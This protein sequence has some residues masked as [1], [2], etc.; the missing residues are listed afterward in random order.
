MNCGSERQIFSSDF[1]WDMGC[2][3]SDGKLYRNPCLT[4]RKNHERPCRTLALRNFLNVDDRNPGHPRD[5]D[6]DSEVTTS[7]SYQYIVS[8][9][10]ISKTREIRES[11]ERGREIE[12]GTEDLNYFTLFKG[13][14]DLLDWK[15]QKD[16]LLFGVNTKS[17]SLDSG[18]RV[19]RSVESP[20]PSADTAQNS[21]MGQ[22]AFSLRDIPVPGRSEWGFAVIYITEF[23]FSLYSARIWKSLHRGA[24]CEWR[25]VNPGRNKI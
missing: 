3:T 1:Q 16:I 13:N 6:R 20:N 2:R 15:V 8:W 5:I 17:Q 12:S 9:I 23:L 14:M 21:T 10:I 7:S 11:S 19:A 24:K 22:H 18:D 4:G 25:E